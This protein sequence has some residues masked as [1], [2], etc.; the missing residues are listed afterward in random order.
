EESVALEG[1]VRVVAGAH[2]L[3]D[4]LDW[5][6]ERRDAVLL[7]MDRRRRS[8]SGAVVGRREEAELGRLELADVLE[9][10]RQPLPELRRALPTA[11][12]VLA[13]PL[14][15][16]HVAPLLVEVVREAQS[17]GAGHLGRPGSEL[18]PRLDECL[19]AARTRLPGPRCVD[20]SH[21]RPPF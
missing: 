3:E 20:R 4:P 17:A 9:D 1:L 7:V 11:N 6:V 19:L 5:C 15:E 14:A 8:G 21:L 18:L 12:R 10:L 16:A 2:V 13:R